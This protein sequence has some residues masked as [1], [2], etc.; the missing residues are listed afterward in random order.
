[1]P[2]PTSRHGDSVPLVTT[3]TSRSS[4]TTA[5]PWRGMPAP[6]ST[7]G[8]SFWSVPC[9][10][11]GDPGPGEPERGEF[12]VG[13]LRA[14]PGDGLGADEARGLLAAPAEPGLDGVAA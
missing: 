13:A 9:S 2:I 8:P 10:R 12:R 14:G 11:A 1:M 6:V 3:P 4:R 7:N 5:F